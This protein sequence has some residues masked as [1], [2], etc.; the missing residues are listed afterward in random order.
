MAQVSSTQCRV[1][2]VA[3]NGHR[4]AF[5]S[6]DAQQ[7]LLA[8][9]VH[10]DI[11]EACGS[12]ALH[13][14][15]KMNAQGRL[16]HQI[17]P[18]RSLVFIDLQRDGDGPET[19][20]KPTVMVGLTDDQGMSENYLRAQPQRNVTIRGREISSVILDA[21]LFYHARLANDPKFGTLTENSAA[22]GPLQL[23][24]FWRSDLARD[25]ED[26]KIILARILDYFLFKGSQDLEP[27]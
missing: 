25:G 8:V 14:W 15:P 6:A 26:P 1:D 2:I 18:M 11:A 16:W 27:G 17:I 4:I 23:G 9:E 5:T 13:F 19:G 24:L 12:F 3:P 10:K 7:D 22:L 20:E 21:M